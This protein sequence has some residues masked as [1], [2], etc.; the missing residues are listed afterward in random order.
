MQDYDHDPNNAYILI[1][2]SRIQG[3]PVTDYF[4]NPWTLVE[5][6]ALELDWGTYRARLRL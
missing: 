5:N 6:G 4:P 3:N 2:I 1:R